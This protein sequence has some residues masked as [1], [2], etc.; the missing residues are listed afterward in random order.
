[1]YLLMSPKNP[2]QQ[3]EPILTSTN[4]LDYLQENERNYSENLESEK[5]ESEP[6]KI[7]ENE[8]KMT[9]A[10]IAKIPEF[11]GKDNNTSLQEWL[12]KVQKA[13]DANSWNAAKMLKTISY[14]LQKTAEKWF[15]NLEELF[16]NWQAFK[17][18]FLQQFTNNNT[19]ITLCNCFHNIKQETSETILV[20]FIAGLKDKLIK[21]VRPHVPENLAIAIRHA[22]NYEMAIEEANHT[23]LQL[24]KKLTNLQRKLRT[25]SLTSNNSNNYK[26]IS[27]HNNK[28]KPTTYYHQTVKIKVVIIVR[29]QNIGNKIAESYKETNKTGVITILLPASTTSLLFFKIPTAEQLLSACSTAAIST[30]STNSTVSTATYTIIPNIFLF[31]FKANE[32]SFLLSNTVVNEQKAITAMYTETKVEEKPIQ[33]I[34]DIQT[35]IVIADGMKKIPVGEIDNF[36]FTID[37]ITIPVKVLKLKILYQG[38]YTRVPATCD[39]FNKKSEKASVFE[40]EEKRELPV[41]EIFMAFGL[42]SNWAKETEQKIFEETRG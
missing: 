42:P 13:R 20:Q 34:L 28:T 32:S 35:V 19:F 23:K 37:G 29:F 22:K 30:I 41:T 5:T 16:E 12:D 39:I 15:E 24:K 6:E 26:D 38:Q 2:T 25:I 3:Q 18:A 14:F 17:N 7:T 27:H 9:T 36:P 21:K 40:F 4:L 1:M 31:E 10:Y 8:E 33:L 11:T